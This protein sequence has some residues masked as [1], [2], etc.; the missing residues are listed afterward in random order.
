[1]SDAQ[2]RQGEGHHAHSPEQ[3]GAE[4]ERPQ[5]WAAIRAAL[6]RPPNRAQWIVGLLLCGL[7]FGVAVQVS[8]TQEDAL[9]SARTSDLVR[10]LD[11]LSAQRDRLVEEEQQLR[12]TLADL[13]SGADRA[14]AARLATRERIQNLQI[15][16]GTVD[17]HG[18]G[19]VVSI[20][21]PDRALEST[22]LLDA[23]QELRDAGAEA[24][25]INGERVVASTAIVDTPDGVAVGGEVIRPDYEIRAI[26]NSDTLEAG[27]S[28]PGGVLESMTEAGASASVVESSEVQI[29]ALS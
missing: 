16:A 9:A 12:A 25:S 6:R 26:G 24:I 11:D 18:P 1:M 7:G 10:I 4:G 14:R 19:V 2:S 27:M 23:V 20:S 21:D 22:D 28:F 17:V 29:A 3:P 5:G 13:Q 8:T 15:L